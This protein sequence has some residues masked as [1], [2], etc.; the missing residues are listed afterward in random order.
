M[1]TKDQKI[2]KDAEEQN[3]PIFVFTA[4]D[5]L[6]VEVLENY[7]NMCEREECNIDHL[8][9]IDVR[10]YEFKEWQIKNENIVKKPD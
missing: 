8:K 9:G 4:K 3:I 6:S 1:T 2:I 5:L 10:I 7:L